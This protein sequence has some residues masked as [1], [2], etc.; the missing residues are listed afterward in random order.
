MG[1]LPLKE[2]FG[3]YCRKALCS[4][5]GR[6]NIFLPAEKEISKML[7]ENLLSNFKATAEY[8]E[9]AAELLFEANEASP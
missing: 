5:V 1:F 7:A 6:E 9:I 2:A 4:E 8:K 3:E